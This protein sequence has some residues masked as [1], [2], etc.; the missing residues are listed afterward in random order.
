MRDMCCPRGWMDTCTSGGR[1]GVR[2][3]ATARAACR[4]CTAPRLHL[5]CSHFNAC[6]NCPPEEW[7]LYSCLGRLQHRRTSIARQH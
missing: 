2:Q 5:W 4:E 7:I 6:L 3:D 1:P